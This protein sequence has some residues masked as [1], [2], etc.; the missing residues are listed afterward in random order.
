MSLAGK[1]TNAKQVQEK[2]RPDPKLLRGSGS[3][4]AINVAAADYDG[5]PWGVTK[6]N[7]PSSGEAEA[8]V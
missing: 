7:G 4:L 5:P 6:R 3:A 1:F 8:E 2:A